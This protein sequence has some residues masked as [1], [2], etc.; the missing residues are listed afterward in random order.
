VGSHHLDWQTPTPPP[1]GNFTDTVTVHRGPY[2]YSAP[3]HPTD[4][5]TQ[6]T[7]VTVKSS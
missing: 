2:E 7:P 3:G 4:Y 6:N 1:H 5:A